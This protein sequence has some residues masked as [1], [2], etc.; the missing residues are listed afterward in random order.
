MSF[1]SVPAVCTIRFAVQQDLQLFSRPIVE[2]IEH[3]DE[4]V[5]KVRDERNNLP[6][7]GDAFNND[8]A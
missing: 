1:A 6:L 5:P 8:N 2:S 3:V 4:N 7:A